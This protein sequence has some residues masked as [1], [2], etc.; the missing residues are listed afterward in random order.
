MQSEA[1]KTEE[2][3]RGGTSARKGK[4]KMPPEKIARSLA[5]AGLCGSLLY[6]APAP[7]PQRGPGGVAV[8]DWQRNLTAS[9]ALTSWR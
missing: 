2:G 6:R 9:C 3:K 8:N 5:A 7:K 4:K 1:E